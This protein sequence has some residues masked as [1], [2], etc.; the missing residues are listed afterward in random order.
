LVWVAYTL[1]LG[2]CLGWLLG[3]NCLGLAGLV[4]L[5]WVGLH[6]DPWTFDLYPFITFGPL[7][8][9]D[10]TLYS[11]HP[12]PLGPL[13]LPFTFL[14][15]SLGCHLVG[16]LGWIACLG[17]LPGLGRLGLLAQF[18]D[19][20]FP[21]LGY[22]GLVGYP[23]MHTVGPWLDIALELYLVPI[24]WFGCV[25][26]VWFTLVAHPLHAHI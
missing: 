7:V 19:C 3:H 16:F 10:Y 1:G 9:L 23:F 6:L 12:F 25:P 21:H 22:L 18:L 2:S 8:L 15:G 11:S 5:G 14:V 24:I 13:W 17:W 4:Y 20:P 26:L